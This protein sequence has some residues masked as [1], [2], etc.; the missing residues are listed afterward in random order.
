MSKIY[1]LHGFMGT[2]KTHFSN[3]LNF[4]EKENYEVILLDLPGHGSSE[5]VAVDDYFEDAVNWVITKIK[6]QGKGYIIGLSLGASIAVHIALREPNILSGIM[7]TGYSPFI[8][9]ELKSVMEKQYHHFLHIEQ[10]DENVARHFKELHGDKWFDTLQKVLYSQ[11]FHYPSL[12]ET[13]LR[14]LKVP[15]LV[16]NGSNQQHEIDSVHYIKTHNSMVEV[17]LIPQ[18]G[19]TANID[20]PDIYNNM[21]S[22]FLRN[23]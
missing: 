18:A 4:L 9:D 22:E 23:N 15:T 16:L 13:D 8:P 14:D 7:L 11:T 5:K 3:Q 17:G 20:Q 10:N 19:H 12:F 1:M 6:E 2:S 21:M